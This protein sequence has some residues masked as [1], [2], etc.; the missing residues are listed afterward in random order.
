MRLFKDDVNW[1]PINRSSEA[2]VHPVR[3][4]Y[5]STM[6]KT[7]AMATDEEEEE[8][9]ATSKKLV[10]NTK[11]DVR[12]VSSGDFRKSAAPVAAE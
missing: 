10:D 11:M 6:T 5:L 9:G 2:D 1:T 4:S 3:K 8:D 7:T 12:A